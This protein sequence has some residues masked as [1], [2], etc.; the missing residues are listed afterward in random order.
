MMRFRFRRRILGMLAVIVLASSGAAGSVQAQKTA[1]L[2]DV[3]AYGEAREW[4]RK[5]E[6]LIGTAKE[7]S[8]EQADLFRKAITLKPD[9]I[10]AHFNL[11]LIL[12]HQKKTEGAA[13]EFEAVRKINPDF[14]ANGESI[15]Q[16]LSV[17]YRELGKNAEALAALHEGLK[18]QPKSLSML[19]ALAYLQVHG[20]Q[21][22]EAVP[23]L[24]AIL[25]IDPLDT[26]ARINLAILLQKLRRH[27]EAMQNYRLVIEQNPSDFS[28]HFNLAILLM[29][30]NQVED[31]I[32]EFERADKISPGNEELL[33]RLGDAYISQDRLE[34]AAQSFRAAAEK[35]PERAVLLSKLA[36]VLAQLKRIPDAVAVLE[37]SVR[38]APGSADAFYLLGDLYSELGRYDDSVIAYNRSLKLN[39]KQR[40]VR[41][42]LG[43]LYAES[44]LFREART[45]LKAAVEIDPDYAAAWSNLAVVCE[46]LELDKEA[47][48]A[49][50]KVVMLG[51]AL[52]GN[53]FRLGI[54]YAKDNQPDPAIA[55]FARAIQMEPEKYRQILREELKNVHSVLDSVRYKDAFI[56][57]LSSGSSTPPSPAIKK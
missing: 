40:E 35:A 44:K 36:F 43:T 27:D 47:I 32:Q 57:L 56:R 26:D 53:Y 17:V 16:L 33:E 31:A 11:G 55:N 28:A 3:K 50:E 21:D 15:H 48:E 51:K 39:P 18:K 38:I 13:E 22:T 5:A 6:D 23:T 42:N 4:F 25:D 8:E 24:Q 30:R 7:N 29:S 12:I 20:A 34:K 9:F 14:E 1:T 10:E 41:Y 37:K 52:A 2:Q 46:R 19:K 54:L 49:N 45:E